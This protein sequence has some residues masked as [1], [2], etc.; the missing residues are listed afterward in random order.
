MAQITLGPSP[1]QQ[2]FNSI[3]SG[4]PAGLSVRTGSTATS[5][6]TS[7]AFT[8]TAVAWNN[9]S[10]GF[11][12]FASATDL[13]GT[14][15][16][17]Q[18]SSS[19]NRSLGIR[20][21][22]TLGDPGA[23]F[24]MQ[25]ANTTNL[26]DFELSF[27]LQSLD[28]S[29]PRTTTWR[30]DYGLGSNPASFTAAVASGALTTGGN[31]FANNTVTV[32]FGNSLDNKNETIW[33]RIVA[34]TPSTGSGNR[35]SSAI[36]DLSLSYSSGT[37]ANPSLSV[38][39][40]SLS[41]GNQAFNTDSVKS[42]T[43]NYADL[44]G[45]NVVLN[46]SEPFAISK[47][48]IG[49]FSTSL[50]Y[51]N[52]ELSGTS[53]TVYTRFRPVA[54]GASNGTISHIGGGIT[55]PVIVS[56]SGNGI[57]ADPVA[58]ADTYSV[59]TGQTLSGNVSLNDSD[60]NG[61]VLT[62]SKLSDPAQG[63][64]TF[65]SNGTFTYQAPAENPSVQTFSYRATNVQGL[66]SDATVTINVNEKSRVIISQYYEGASVNKWIELTN[67]GNSPVNIASPQLKLALYNISGDGGTINITS[68]PSQ[69]VNLNITIP[70]KSS[71]L[72]GNTGNGNE[73]PY[74]TASSASQTSNAVINFNGN[75]GIAL[76]DAN[77][78]ILDV[79]GQGINAKDVSYVRNSD[80]STST[81]EFHDHDWTRT[82]LATVQNAVDIDD[83]N[84]L[85]VHVQPDLP[86][87]VNPVAQPS[88]LSFSAVGTKSISM[89]FTSATADEYLI[90]RSLN[91]SLGAAPLDGT[92][93]KTGDT[94]GGGVVAGRTANPTFTDTN[95]QDGTTFY[96]FIF[97]LNNTS[98]DGGPKYLSTNPLTGTQATTPLPVCVAPASQ[99]SNFTI[100]YSN[101]NF[102]QGTFSTVSGVDEYLVVMSRD[103]L[104]SSNP[105]SQAIYSVGDSIGGGIVI[106]KGASGT[107]NRSSLAQN[108]NY[109]FY[110]FSVNSNCS[111]GPLY[112]TAA[113]LT[114][115]QKTGI[116]NSNTLNF[117]YGNLHSHSSYSDG[118]KDDTSKKPEDDYA[119]AKNSKKM[120][121]LGLSEHNHTQAG[122]RLSN[123]KLGIEAAKNSTSP[124]FI[125]LHGMEWGVI[126]GGGHVLVYGIDSLIGWE[127]GEHQI[128][129]PKSVYTGSTGLFNVINRHGLN[130][131]ATLAHPNTSDF[132]N[133]SATY[134]LNADNAIVGTALASGPAF[135]TNVTY[136]DPASS[137]SYLSY[138]NRMLA[139]GY[140]LGASIDHD[141]H[142][143]TFG[144]HTRARLVV[145]APAL[146]EN[147]LL[148]GMKKMRFYASEDSAAKVT[149]TINSQPIGSIFTGN[150]A[151]HISVSTATTSPVTSIKILFGKPGSGVIAAPVASSASGS[152][153]FTDSTLTNLNTGYY[154]ADIL[155]ADGSRIITS[156]IWYTRDDSFKSE[157]TITFNALP[158]RTYGEPDFSPVASSTS[159]LPIVYSSSNSNVATIVDGKIHITGAGTTTITAGNPG[160]SLYLPAANVQQQLVVNKASQ[161]ITLDSLETKFEGDPDFDLTSSGSS[162]LQISFASSD[163][164][165]AKI[166]GN[167]VSIQG[168]GT[169]VITASQS[170]DTNYHPAQ[171]VSRALTVTALPVPQITANGPLAF[172][173]QD[174]VTLSSATAS[175]YQWFKDGS[176]ISGQ[177][178]QNIIAKSS[179]AYFVEVTYSNGFKKR[180]S[181]ID[182]NASDTI[183]PQVLTKN[184]TIDLVN[185][186]AAITASDINNGSSDNCGI[187]SLGINKSSFDCSSIGENIITLTATDNS[188]NVSSSNAVVTITG[189]VP[190]TAILLSRTDNTI[191]GLPDNTIAL[192]YGTQSLTLTAANGTEYKWSPVT[193]LNTS[194]GNVSVFSP[195]QAGN[196]TISVE[197]KNQFGCISSAS[198]TIHVIDVRCGNK[199][200]KVLVRDDKS[201]KEICI[202]SNA[203]D[204]HLKKGSRFGTVGSVSVTSSTTISG[205]AE[206]GKINSVLSAYPNP[207]AKTTTITFTLAKSQ[208]RVVLEIYDLN[209]KKLKQLYEGVAEANR[210]YNFQFDTTSYSEQFFL[211]RLVTAGEVFTFRLMKE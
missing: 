196:Y 160:S 33:I 25:I 96:Y 41:F 145:L 71:V 179:G 204:T 49:P 15:T 64:L 107:F 174:S 176:P 202:S 26:K 198:I 135:S 10:G 27:K 116:L 80:V 146:T 43:L 51:N 60:P 56:L 57:S 58:V 111:G 59:L 78:T 109:Y 151:P 32:D 197:A 152:L 134:D 67:L 34:I 86:D 44:D 18:Q 206:E 173:P 104:L 190:Q 125:A 61:S 16:S 37:Q 2:D 200:E 91:S 147:D 193:Y 183:A 131:I 137:M 175:G 93:Y 108:T 5:L 177:S 106:K 47:S 143:M 31:T 150:G 55:S 24:V 159:G 157:Q 46:T 161:V 76:L 99:P 201:G 209:G 187:A 182:V 121:F 191:T 149:Y 40:N 199:M 21:T 77:N 210:N 110:L 65:N 87:C 115:K 50:T 122:M 97:S 163:T 19:S 66:S 102:I 132:N 130:A 92:L 103:S 62:F 42:Y 165:V 75:D 23:A 155:E 118:N 30:V 9:T 69:I 178:A 6:G 95:L 171:P 141:N 4:L 184:I 136:S 101:Y 138:Y 74:L 180:S 119:F 13:S 133:I 85:G 181:S 186:T 8:T 203:V 29:S 12:N 168:P 1:Y 84:R 38:A 194:T 192:G 48:A 90:V 28:A 113:P 100:T 20:Q 17:V 105:A 207:F 36:D 81:P 120:D 169:A 127:A 148:D 53:T 205:Q 208:D 140:H 11:K 142:N 170:G 189:E 14:A 35:P 185:G 72:I 144:R 63:V 126:S 123:W 156:P 7:V 172:C 52:S 94:L 45:S 195:T 158:A 112:L 73:V 154:Y 22:G 139:K 117:Y 83:P 114:G 129:V 3:S 70:A 54:V 98:C 153:S 188:G 124:D 82:T 128:Y 211:A 39:P 166:T 167:K 88:A 164:L 79:F 89:S 162:G 68:T